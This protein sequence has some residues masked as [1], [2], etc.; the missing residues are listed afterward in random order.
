[1]LISKLGYQAVCG[2]IL[3]PA[4]PAGVCWC[5]LHNEEIQIRLIPFHLQDELFKLSRDLPGRDIVLFTS[6]YIIRYKEHHGLECMGLYIPVGIIEKIR[7]SGT[8]E[9]ALDDSVGRHIPFKGFPHPDTGTACKENGLRGIGILP[10]QLL[11]HPH[12]LF[13]IRYWLGF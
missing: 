7:H 3:G 1:M 4:D 11:K 12:T 9:P 13:K 6:S 8:A 10:I 5:Y 2:P